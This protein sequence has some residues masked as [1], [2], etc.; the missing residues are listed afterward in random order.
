MERQQAKMVPRPPARGRSGANASLLRALPALFA[1]AA[2][3]WL[4]TAAPRPTSASVPSPCSAAGRAYGRGTCVGDYSGTCA[5]ITGSAVYL[6]EGWN[7]AQLDGLVA[8]AAQAFESQASLIPSTC[9]HLI[10][11][12]VCS[13]GA[14]RCFNVT[15]DQGGVQGVP[16]LPCKSVCD[17]LWSQCDGVF[18]LY[19]LLDVQTPANVNRTILPFCGPGDTFTQTPD[20]PADAFG[21][22]RE[23]PFDLYP[24]GLTGALLFPDGGNDFALPNGTTIFEPCFDPVV[25]P[26]NDFVQFQATVSC[27]APLEP[28][29][30]S[31]ECVLACPLPLWTDAALSSIQWAFIAPGLVGVVLA[32][33]VFVDSLATVLTAA[34]VTTD[35][36]RAR[37]GAV[38]SRHAATS[39]SAKSGSAASN[40][41]ALAAAA[42]A[43][44]PEA[45]VPSV[46]VVSSVGG[47]PVSQQASAASP[48][49]PLVA[50]RRHRDPEAVSHVRLRKLTRVRSS[51][52]YALAGSALCIVYFFIGPFASLVRG[53]QVSC[54][55]DPSA[56]VTNED[57]VQGTADVSGPMCRAQ[58]AS[59]FVLQLIF[60]L[61]L[62]ALA[63]ML[64]ASRSFA[65]APS[66]RA[67]AAWRVALVVYCFGMP[68][69]CLIAAMSLDQL[70]TNL[71]TGTEQLLRSAAVCALRVD[72]TTEIVL[73][74][75]PFCITG[76]LVV[77]TSGYVFRVLRR[78]QRATAGLKAVQSA[79]DASLNSLVERLAGLGLLTLCV[80]VAQMVATGIVQ[81]QLTVFSAAFAAFWICGSVATA[82]TNCTAQADASNAALPNDAA[83]AVQAFAMSTV[84]ALYSGFFA[85]QAASKIWRRWLGSRASSNAAVGSG[86]SPSPRAPSRRILSNP[87][88]AVLPAALTVGGE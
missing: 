64:S 28:D 1:L 12:T 2:S 70:S 14:M 61:M 84:T 31:S 40:P 66:K 73:V 22:G 17:E 79:T 21:V 55:D 69:A 88:E 58:R 11:A 10:D 54:S 74:F 77:A 24:R 38:L 32:T 76:A 25:L 33:F 19:Y 27:P 63:E 53:N 86:S 37:L 49:F 43:D 5:A 4:W 23:L 44:V 50:A 18:Q 48:R 13:L 59:P 20:Q 8:S 35:V 82:C 3:A 65:H 16:M 42:T 7:A 39:P 85:T 87:G 41:A 81:E 9:R 68:L 34:G 45:V 71:I 78:A 36:V 47:L 83:L 6:P 46:V 75:V 52:V 57:V 56:V 62:Y 26:G 51:T 72:Q 60:N 67:R 15:D 30:G 29:S 80:L